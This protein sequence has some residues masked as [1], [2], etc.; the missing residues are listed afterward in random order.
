MEHLGN[1]IMLLKQLFP[2]RLLLPSP[3]VWTWL[4]FWGPLLLGGAFPSWT[5]SANRCHQSV[6]TSEKQRREASS[7]RGCVTDVTVLPETNSEFTP[8]N[9]WPFLE[10]LLKGA[11]LVLGRGHPDMCFLCNFDVSVRLRNLEF[12]LGEKRCWYAIMSKCI[13]CK[14]REMNKNMNLKQVVNKPDPG[15]PSKIE[16]DLT[17][18]GPLIY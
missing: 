12:R 5:L 9:W 8:E 16:W 1:K 6:T 11:M 13:L 15:S 7:D 18:N 17:T 3:P 4:T 2:E 10:G 14:A